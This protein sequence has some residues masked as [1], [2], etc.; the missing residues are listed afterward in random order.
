MRFAV[1]LSALLHVGLLS[2]LSIHLSFDKKHMPLPQ[3]VVVDLVK[4]APNTNLPKAKAK[5]Q[6]PKKKKV[7]QRKKP[8][9]KQA[10]LPKKDPIKKQNAPNKNQLTIPEKEKNLTKKN[11]KTPPDRTSAPKTLKNAK[12]IPQQ[13]PSDIP[14]PVINLEE[15]YDDIFETLDSKIAVAETKNHSEEPFDPEQEL[16]ADEQRI[17]EQIISEQLQLRWNQDSG[18]LDADQIHI[19][20]IIDKNIFRF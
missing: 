13:K 7:V 16:T 12:I 6:P 14:P 3:T 5:P 4:V 11:T 17:I 20:I 8:A 18:K 2:A 9:P 10:T 15:R 1:I 19:T